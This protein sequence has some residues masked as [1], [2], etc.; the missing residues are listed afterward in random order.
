MMAAAATEDEE[1][2]GRGGEEDVLH[3]GYRRTRP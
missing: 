1:G 3:G 2:E